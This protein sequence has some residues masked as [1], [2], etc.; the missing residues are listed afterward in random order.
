MTTKKPTKKVP[1][2]EYTATV[3]IMGKNF[4]AKGSS[5]TE[6]VDNLRPGSVA[7]RCILTVSRGQKSKERVMYPFFTRKLFRTQGTARQI[8]LKQVAT[9]FDV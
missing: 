1:K 6:A 5:I 2:P 3:S 4:T 7:G 9:L 8:L